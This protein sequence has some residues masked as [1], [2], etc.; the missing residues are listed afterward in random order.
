MG[1]AEEGSEASGEQSGGRGAT[2]P[3]P[4]RPG[5][6]VEGL[7]FVGAVLLHHL[8]GVDVVVVGDGEQVEGVCGGVCDAV[9]R[10]DSADAERATAGGQ[11]H[12]FPELERAGVLS[13]SAG[14]EC[15]GVPGQQ[16]EVVPEPGGAGGSGV[17]FVGSVPVR[18][19]RSTVQSESS[20]G[21]S[22]ASAV[23]HS[24]VS[25]VGKRLEA[26]RMCVLFLFCFSR[27]IWY[28]KRRTFRCL[29]VGRHMCSLGGQRVS[30]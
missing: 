26:H 15:A 17:E 24:G 5:Q 4:G 10:S 7:G 9:C 11:H 19:H 12:L 22:S 1:D 18:E 8:P 23:H 25:G 28:D 14:R 21:V 27:M 3:V 29:L 6:G 30:E 16:D 20:G 13:V 2:E